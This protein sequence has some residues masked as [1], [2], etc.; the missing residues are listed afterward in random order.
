MGLCRCG[1]NS[2]VSADGTAG[3]SRAAT[4]SKCMACPSEPSQTEPIVLIYLRFRGDRLMLA[5]LALTA[6]AH[7]PK[8]GAVRFSGLGP[9]ARHV[10][11][12]S[13]DAEVYFNQSLEFMYGFNKDEAIRGFKE[14][15][16]LDPH[17]AIAYWGLA[18]ANGPD[19]NTPAIDPDHNRAGYE[20]AVQARRLEIYASPVEKALI[21]A[22]AKRYA[23][24]PSAD[25]TGLDQVYANEMRTV[26]HRFPKDMDVGALF[27]E[28]LMDLSPWNQWKRDGSPQP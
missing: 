22:V 26:W 1:R 17:C 27:A 11:T 8:P 25:R 21:E 19:I 24:P 23:K 16:R 9:Y 5:V 4:I 18:E 20:A 14:A 6:I 28:S 2:A 3:T 10:T 15:I 12:R 13:R 7:S